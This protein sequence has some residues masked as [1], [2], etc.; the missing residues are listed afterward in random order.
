MDMTRHKQRID[1]FE[2]S[3]L[4]AFFMYIYIGVLKTS[5]LVPVHMSMSIVYLVFKITGL[6]AMLTM[7]FRKEP[8]LYYKMG[9][10]FLLVPVYAL[11][12]PSKNFD[13]FYYFIFVV[14]AYAISF[15]KILKAYV[16]SAV[17]GTASVMALCFFGIIPNEV[18]ARQELSLARNSFGF[19]TP[20]DFA[21]RI[22]FILLAY[23]MLKK[24]AFSWKENLFVF[25]LIF[26]I[27]YLTN[28]RL[29]TLLLLLLPVS[30]IFKP[31]LK[32][33]VYCL[34]KVGSFLIS[35]LYIMFSILIAACYN[36]DDQ[37]LSFLN[38][39]LSDRIK[40]GHQA[41]REK[42]VTLLGQHFHEQGNG[43]LPSGSFRYFYIDSSY[44]R[45]LVIYG[46]IIS[47]LMLVAIYFLHCRFISEGSFYYSLGF[48]LVII[49]SAVDQH[50]LDPSYNVLFLAMFANIVKRKVSV[51]TNMDLKEQTL[52]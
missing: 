23:Y 27:Y 45:L 32:K 16:F 10:V 29:D 26:V 24:F 42:G 11:C 30:A 4:I 50:F 15:R 37:V 1:I 25:V 33:I 14:G 43:L 17:V 51:K 48:F 18:F 47:S 49:S 13:F 22:F 46:V 12:V 41:F 39:M 8:N 31:F 21:A 36:S 34:G 2:L 40:I 20:T 6:C 52:P 9:A 38:I 3:Y 35:F 28:A 5:L 19:F 7:L 44:I